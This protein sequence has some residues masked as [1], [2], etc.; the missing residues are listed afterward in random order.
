MQRDLMFV[1]VD[2]AALDSL[3]IRGQL[4][5]SVPTADTR[6][7]D[8]ATAVVR[9]MSLQNRLKAGPLTDKRYVTGIPALEPDKVKFFSWA[10]DELDAALPGCMVPK[11]GVV[12][13]V[14]R[15]GTAP[16]PDGAGLAQLA[17][18]SKTM[19]EM[20]DLHGNRQIREFTTGPA[21][22]VSPTRPTRVDVFLSHAT[23]DRGIAAEFKEALEGAQPGCRVFVAEMDIQAGSMWSEEIRSTLLGSRC[24]LL[25]LTP[26]SVS[27]GWVMAEVGALWALNIP[28]VPAVQYVDGAKL[29]E[30]ITE[31]QTVDIRTSDGRRRC[32]QAILALLAD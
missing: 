4:Q 12:L 30:F 11:P 3:Q 25:L 7:V 13:A 28:W 15:T 24:A 16:W 5:M 10:C 29:P 18:T 26:H 6:I 21:A 20:V 1:V 14:V 8:H 17:I 2:M 19:V 22:H 32:I 31:R 23:A 27:S 9:T